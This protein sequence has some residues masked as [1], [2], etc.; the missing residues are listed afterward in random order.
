VFKHWFSY[1]HWITVFGHIWLLYYYVSLAL[2][3]NIL[4]VNG[5][6]IRSWWI[7]HHY[8]S[9]A[10]SIVILTWPLTDLHASFLPLFTF[11]FFYQAV[12]MHFQAFYQERRHYSLVAQGK[13]TQMDVKN[14]EGLREYNTNMLL[15]PL[16][17]LLAGTYALQVYVS[18]SL[19]QSAF[20]SEDLNLW[21]NPIYYKQE[22]QVLFL[23]ASFAVLAVGNSVSLFRTV[24]DKFTSKRKPDAGTS[25]ADG[26]AARPHED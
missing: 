8:I 10:M 19:L 22:L 20:L 18:F 15:V 16:I 26:G 24:A 11:F 12:I 17:I 2:R 7:V 14:P 25:A 13:A 4:L 1:T 6:R 9:A 21:Q 23:G 5:S 3:E